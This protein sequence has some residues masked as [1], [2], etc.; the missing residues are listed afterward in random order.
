[1]GGVVQENFKE[2]VVLLIVAAET[3]K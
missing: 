2:N 3:R 1:V